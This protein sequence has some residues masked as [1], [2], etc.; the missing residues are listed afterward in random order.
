MTAVTSLDFTK[1]TVIYLD[2][3]YYTTIGAM[4]AMGVKQTTLSKEIRDGNIEPKIHPGG[5]LFSKDAVNIWLDRRT[6]R[7][8]VSRKKAR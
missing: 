8:L 3:E 2:D 5:Y 7:I 6:K 4:K 1:E